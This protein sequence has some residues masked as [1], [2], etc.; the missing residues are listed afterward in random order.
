MTIK[1][2]SA[3][4][5]LGGTLASCSSWVRTG[6]LTSISTRN[7]DDSK[8]Y[9]L[10]KRDVEAIA[11]SESNALNQALDNLTAQHR[12]EFI[13]NAKVYVKDNGKQIKVIGDV[14]GIQTAN[15]N[16]TTVADVEVKLAIG[17]RVAFRERIS[18][19]QRTKK[20][21]EGKIVEGTIIGFNANKVI[22]EYDMGKKAELNYEDITKIS[23]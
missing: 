11:K 7:I 19:N 3:F 12:G 5:L 21:K 8:T 23:K 1:T 16:I 15:T 4:L 10:L 14:W 2:L 6:S 18:V 13:R 17:D 9:V 20:V 22:V